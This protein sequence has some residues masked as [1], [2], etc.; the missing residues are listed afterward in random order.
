MSVGLKPSVGF[1]R[2]MAEQ[3]FAKRPSSAHRP[4][5]L[6]GVFRGYTFTFRTDTG[7]FSGGRL[8]R[9]T[10]LLLAAL[11][12]RPR[13]SLLDLGCGYGAIGIIAARLSEG[14]H[15]ILTDVNERAVALARA[16]LT[17]NKIANAEVRQGDLYEP[18]DGIAFDHIACNPPIRAGRAVLDRIVAEAPRHLR[19][20]GS[21]WLVVRTRQGADS[22]RTRMSAAFGNADI[23]KRG[24]G[25][26]VIRSV[27]RDA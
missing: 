10:E 14:G 9:G 27:K 13:E 17:K 7:V 12:V 20:G 3:Y 2:S 1:R 26:K 18:V 21:L 24:T 16:N 6:R 22:I 15:V 4:R 11:E 19:D 23:V 5:E 25:F 8:D